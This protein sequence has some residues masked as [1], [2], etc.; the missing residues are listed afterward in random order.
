M[1]QTN[2]PHGWGFRSI[3]GGVI[4]DMKLYKVKSPLQ[5]ISSYT[6]LGLHSPLRGASLLAVLATYTHTTT[7]SSHFPITPCVPLTEP[8]FPDN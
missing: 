2:R 1:Q 6:D 4:K 5:T 7:G 8:S 3:N